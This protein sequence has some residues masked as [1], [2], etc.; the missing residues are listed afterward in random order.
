MSVICVP[1]TIGDSGSLCL[2]CNTGRGKN[3]LDTS[4]KLNQLTWTRPQ[5]IVSNSIFL[6]NECLDD[7]RFLLEPNR[8]EERSDADS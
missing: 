4:V 8:Y 5:H 7:L 2:G 6:C 1:T 3:G